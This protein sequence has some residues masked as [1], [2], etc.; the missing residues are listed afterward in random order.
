MIKFLFQHFLWI[1][2]VWSIN[3]TTFIVTFKNN[4]SYQQ[5]ST[6]PLPGSILKVL[7]VL[8]QGRRYYFPFSDEETES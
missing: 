1:C 8:G 3:V 2:G 5:L 7:N 6:Y 4:Y